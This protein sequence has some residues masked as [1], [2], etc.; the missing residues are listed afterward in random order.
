MA[1]SLNFMAVFNLGSIN[2]DLVYRLSHF[3]APGETLASRSFMRAL[4]GKGANQ[5]IALAAAGARIF[6]IG[7][8]NPEDFW[9]IEEMRRRN[10]DMTHVQASESPTGHAI[11]MVND[12]GENQ[13]V[14]CP[15]ANRN[16]DIA[17]ALTALDSATPED[18]VL[19]QNETNGAH[20]FVAAAKA[21]GLKIAYSAAPFEAEIALA[22]L[23]DCDLLV[24]NEGEAAELMAATGRE[25][26]AL[27]LEHLVITYGGKGAEYIGKA[28]RLQQDAFAVNAVDTTGAGDCFFGYFLAGVASETPIETALHEASAAAAL[29]VTKPG[30]AEAIPQRHE[31]LAFIESHK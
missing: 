19:L 18:W 15:G 25:A 2:I 24:V 30:A 6:H 17:T 29:Q 20:E 14:L 31:V 26:D 28:G 3:P 27:G 23:P 22:L 12:E 1:G 5:S 13:I 10:V 8:T 16:I 9:L 21:R 7:A 11:V 4:G